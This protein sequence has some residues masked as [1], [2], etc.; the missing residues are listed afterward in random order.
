MA[1]LF[2]GK[3]KIILFSSLSPTPVMDLLEK[4]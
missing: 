1:I 3:V 2:Y 4:K